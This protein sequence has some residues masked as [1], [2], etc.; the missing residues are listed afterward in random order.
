MQLYSTCH[1]FEN[2]HLGRGQYST[3]LEAASNLQSITQE[4]DLDEFL[5]TARLAETDFTAGM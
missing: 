3:D 5:H 1:I 4:R 2:A